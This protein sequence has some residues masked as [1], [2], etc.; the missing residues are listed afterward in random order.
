[1]LVDRK[2]PKWEEV[3]KLV[4][5]LKEKNAESV[6]IVVVNYLAAC[7]MKSKKDEEA[8]RFLEMMDQFSTPYNASEKFGPLLMSLGRVFLSD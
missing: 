6:R 5:R 1:M 3:A 7:L 4:T 8:I 2:R